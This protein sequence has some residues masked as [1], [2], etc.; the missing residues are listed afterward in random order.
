MGLESDRICVPGQKSWDLGLELGLGKISLGQSQDKNLLDNRISSTNPWDKN[1][2]DSPG[3]FSFG[4]QVTGTKIFG[5]GC[6]VPCPSLEKSVKSA[7]NK[8]KNFWLKKSEK[9][10]NFEEKLRSKRKN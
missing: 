5:T 1:R 2:W 8:R 3:I 7:K 6:P 9:P 10:K 4:T